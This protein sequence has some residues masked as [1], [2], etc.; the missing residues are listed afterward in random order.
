[1]LNHERQ[2]SVIEQMEQNK[3]F[4]FY[5]TGSKFFVGQ[6]NDTDYF[7]QHDNEVINWLWSIGFAEISKKT[8]GD[9]NCIAVL[10]YVAP[11]EQIDVQI[12]EDCTLKIRVQEQFK[13]LGLGYSS[14]TKE[15]WNLAFALAK[16]AA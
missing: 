3:E 5:L 16:I 11:Y 8:Y 12:V 4:M 14:P 10:R 1:M 7:V 15:E 13:K 6:G 2:K 9:N